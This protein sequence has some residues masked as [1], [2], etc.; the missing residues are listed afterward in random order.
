MPDFNISSL[1]IYTIYKAALVN[2]FNIS[3]DRMTCDSKQYC[4]NLY[5]CSYFIC[6]VLDLSTK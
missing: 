6:P 5:D 4:R 3:P 1:N 2:C